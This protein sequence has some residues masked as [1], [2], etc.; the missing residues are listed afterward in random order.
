MKEVASRL[1]DP[2][3]EVR[4]GLQHGLTSSWPSLASWM[5]DGLLVHC[6]GGS[7]GGLQGGI[8]LVV[9]FKNQFLQGELGGIW[10]RSFRSGL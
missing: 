4:S 2:A 1:G 7:G 8:K 9:Q 5:S 10:L 3:C 6:T